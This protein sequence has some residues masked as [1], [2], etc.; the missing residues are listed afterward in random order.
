[1]ETVTLYIRR[2]AT[3]GKTE[4][5]N[6]LHK[7]GRFGWKQVTLKWVECVYDICGNERNPGM[8]ADMWED[9]ATGRRAVVFQG[10]WAY[11]LP[12]TQP[13]TRIPAWVFLDEYSRVT[14]DESN[15]VLNWMNR[16]FVTGIVLPERKG[17]YE[18]KPSSPNRQEGIPFVGRG[19]GLS[20][21]KLTPADMRAM[22]AHVEPAPEG[23]QSKDGSLRFRALSR[24]RFDSDL[25]YLVYRDGMPWF[26]TGKYEIVLRLFWNYANRAGLCKA[27]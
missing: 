12:R 13:G 21:F 5:R 24:H 2:N 16:H 15:D 17:C 8:S 9:V 25:H 4:F 27:A 20:L 3:T 1:M 11:Y 10:A 23:V 26:V 14:F 19:D 22:N 6:E 18:R 7:R